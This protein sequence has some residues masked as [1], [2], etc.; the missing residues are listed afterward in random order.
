MNNMKVERELKALPRT[1]RVSHNSLAILAERRKL[2]FQCA[3]SAECEV[4]Q[5]GAMSTDTYVE[6]NWI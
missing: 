6:P 5:V 3:D 1:R 4:S 2:I